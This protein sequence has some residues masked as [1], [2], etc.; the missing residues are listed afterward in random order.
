VTKNLTYKLLITP[1][2]SSS[3]FLKELTDREVTVSSGRLFQVF[4]APRDDEI[5]IRST[6][7]V[8]LFV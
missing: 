6:D 1:D 7:A 3:L 4:V 8:R 5:A 2:C